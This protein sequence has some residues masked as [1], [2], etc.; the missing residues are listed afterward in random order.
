MDDQ[1]R[2]PDLLV[3]KFYDRWLG[4]FKVT[5]HCSDL[6]YKILNAD[7]RK[8][9]RVHFNLLKAASRKTER[10]DIGQNEPARDTNEESSDEEV[11]LIDEVLNLPTVA[12]AAVPVGTHNAVTAET[13]VSNQQVPDSLASHLQATNNSAV[14]DAPIQS[15]AALHAAIPVVNADNAS[16]VAAPPTVKPVIPQRGGA[17]RYDLR[18]RPKPSTKDAFLIIVAL[19]LLLP[20]AACS[21]PISQLV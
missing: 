8:T 2:K 15:L 18:P 9:K 20:L 13:T 3:N 6:V 19:I 12:N 16:T 17:Q 10:D 5:K 21:S 4:P 14:P 1:Q 11:P 7:S